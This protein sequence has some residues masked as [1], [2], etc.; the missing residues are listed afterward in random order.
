MVETSYRPFTAVPVSAID[1]AVLARAREPHLERGRGIVVR[2]LGQTTS[3]A[4]VTQ[5]EPLALLPFGTVATARSIHHVTSLDHDSLVAL[6]GEVAQVDV[7]VGLGGG[8]ALDAAK[9]VAWQRAVP[10]WM[11]PTAVSVDAWVTNTIAVR[12]RGSVSYQGFVAADRILLDHDLI[13]GAPRRLN[14]AGIGD[15]VS[16]HTAL[17]DWRSG[18]P[19]AATWDAAVAETAAEVLAD[20][21]AAIDE[22]RRVS[23]RGINAI[24]LAHA[25]I[26]RLCL[27]VGHSQMEEGSEHYLAYALEMA[28]GRS[29]VHGQLVGLGTVVVAWLQD[30]DPARVARWLDDA[31]VEWRPAALGLDLS[32]IDAALAGLPGF[33]AD[34]GYPGVFR[35]W[36]ADPG[37]MPTVPWP[38][39]LADPPGPGTG[40]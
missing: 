11:C 26:N 25:T 3:F 5:P 8:M 38:Q 24:A 16:I 12:D 10:L 28:T 4:L 2:A 13:A 32:V 21:V 19:Y 35:R 33:V 34:H 27:D 39:L 40:S 7:I 29:F 1:D 20:L 15:V 36:L 31:G 30:N 14:R 17:A 22:V 9:A 18:G 6:A 37:A 23:E